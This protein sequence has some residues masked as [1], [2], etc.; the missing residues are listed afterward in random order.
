LLLEFW[1][2]TQMLSQQQLL[3]RYGWLLSK[4]VHLRAF[5]TYPQELQVL[6]ELCR[7]H[8]MYIT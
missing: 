7:S 6:S 3:G 1:N 4:M 8:Y 5:I 2:H